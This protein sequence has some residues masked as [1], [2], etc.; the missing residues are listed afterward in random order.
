MRCSASRRRNSGALSVS[1]CCSR[2][3]VAF[4]VCFIFGWR[5]FPTVPP[6]AL[7]GL[8]RV[9]H[10]GQSEPLYKTRPA[11]SLF[12]PSIDSRSCIGWGERTFKDQY[13]PSGKRM[14]RAFHRCPLLNIALCKKYGYFIISAKAGT[15]RK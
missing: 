7:A 12:H 4:M 15:T 11:A 14:L 10:T 1:S 13:F 8:H 6:H 9:P 5:F 2:A 3:E